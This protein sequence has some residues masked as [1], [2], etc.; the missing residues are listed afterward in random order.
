MPRDHVSQ[1][2]CIISRLS[3]RLCRVPVLLLPR[4]TELSVHQ[5]L[6]HPSLQWAKTQEKSSPCR[7]LVPGCEE[8]Q[9]ALRRVGAVH[10]GERLGAQALL[11]VGMLQRQATAQHLHEHPAELLR[12]HRVQERVDHRAEVEERVREGEED[13]VRPE[14]GPR[15]VVLGFGCSHDPPNLVGHPAYGQCHNNQ[16]WAGTSR[17]GEGER[18][19]RK[20]QHENAVN[21]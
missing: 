1:V 15:P 20:T 13:H 19:Q 2:L 8:E 21:K 14:V 10:G 3:H 9:G 7:G 12:G 5:L 18:R 6:Q 4:E 16:P 11:V 17:S